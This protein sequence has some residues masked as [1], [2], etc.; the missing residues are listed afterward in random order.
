MTETVK[1]AFVDIDTGEYYAGSNDRGHRVFS[2]DLAKAKLYMARP[3]IRNYFEYVT[4]NSNRNIKCQEMEVNFT[5]IGDSDYL[6]QLDNRDF[7]LYKK[8]DK[9][10]DHDIDAMSEEDYRRWRS[11][12]KKFQDT[13]ESSF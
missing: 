11:L 6:D 3:E 2:K 9:E 8:L 7:E 5:V 1:I 12:R 13:K 4:W 10:A